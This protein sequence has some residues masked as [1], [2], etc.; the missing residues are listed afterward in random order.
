MSSITTVLGI[1]IASAALVAASKR[2]ELTS[3]ELVYEKLGGYV[4]T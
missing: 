3:R 4:A 2:C 1:N